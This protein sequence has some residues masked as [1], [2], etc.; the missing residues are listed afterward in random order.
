MLELKLNAFSYD[1]QAQP[2]NNTEANGR[3]PGSSYTN[4][5]TAE[6]KEFYDKVLLEE[7]GPNLVFS[8]FAVKKPIP[9]NNGKKITFR[10]FD[11]L[12]KA[13]SPLVEGVTPDPNALNVAE[14][15][16]NVFQ[17]GAFVALTDLLQMTAVD[18]IIAE[19]T[20]LVSK[21]A[22][23]TI[24]TLDRDVLLQSTNRMY[25]SKWSGTTETPVTTRATMDATSV[26]KVDTIQQVVAKL[27][28]QN[29]P[30]INGDYV[31]IAH[32]Y[33]LYDLMRD[34]EWID[35]NKYTTSEKL[36]NGE[37]G[38]IGGVRF[39]ETTEAKILKNRSGSVSDNYCPLV[40]PS[41]AT[42]GILSVFETV[43][44]GADAYGVSEITGGGLQLIVKQLG[45]GDDPL[46]QRSTVGW[47]LTRGGGILYP[48]YICIIDSISPRYSASAST[49]EN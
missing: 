44:L 43:V 13:L 46:N 33:V 8:Q 15:E 37:V 29:A 6:M 40:D 21:Q 11:N 5:L 36:F 45:A 47:K 18:P 16:I 31:A 20:K 38:K 26:L 2:V 32:P 24:D 25:A 49:A 7:V 9:G 35:A 28:A 42:K 3:T 4:D 19:T 23:G 48:N 10:K 41:D 27:R 34:P 14:Q 30:T 22:K 1:P 39:V 17:H 12:P